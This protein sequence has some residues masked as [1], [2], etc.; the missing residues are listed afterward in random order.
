VYAHPAARQLAGRVALQ[1]GPLVYCLES[2]DNPNVVLDQVA[3]PRTAA[4]HV[5]HKPALLGGVAVITGRALSVPPTGKE[6]YRTT[7]G[8][9]VPI[10]FT[11]VP[12]FVWDNRTPGSMRVWLR[13]G[14]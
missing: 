7:P 14:G 11:A 6:L 4:L 2:V 5:H 12:Y 10:T 1:R 13:D 9:P 8:K 3:L